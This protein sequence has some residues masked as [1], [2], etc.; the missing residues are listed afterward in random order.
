MLKLILHPI[1]RR[2]FPQSLH[3]SLHGQKNI[4]VDFNQRV[5]CKVQEAE[6]GWKSRTGEIRSSQGS[7]HTYCSNA[8]AVKALCSN[9]Q[10][11]TPRDHLCTFPG[12]HILLLVS[13]GILL[14]DQPGPTGGWCSRHHEGN[15]SQWL[16]WCAQFQQH[17]GS[18]DASLN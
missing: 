12:M 15:N 18:S 5:H 6:K 11:E 14:S 7:S 3:T 8:E 9:L 4:S 13:E 2:S 16:H 10:P 1:C 17:H